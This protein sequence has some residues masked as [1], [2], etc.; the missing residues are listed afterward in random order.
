[1]AKGGRLD[2]SVAAFILPYFISAIYGV[3]MW[4]TEGL[5]PAYP[6]KAFLTITKD[7]LLFLLGSISSSIALALF[8]T[9]FDL[10][11]R[12]RAMKTASHVLASSGLF[13]AI[14]AYVVALWSTGGILEAAGLM[15]EGRFSS[16]YP[17]LL[18]FLAFLL[19]VDIPMDTLRSVRS[20]ISPLLILAVI[21]IYYWLTRSDVGGLSLLNFT[22]GLIILAALTLIIERLVTKG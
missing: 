6:S 18:F 1:M 5:P 12:R 4:S 21:P 2:L 13:A 20:Y 14:S 19:S 22:L 7:P 9:S 3:Y 16:I 8:V 11:E 15:A 17:I 10:G